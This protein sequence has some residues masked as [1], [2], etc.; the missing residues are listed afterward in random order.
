[1]QSRWRRQSV[2]WR[3]SRNLNFSSLK[4]TGLK[5]EL[6]VVL[7]AMPY[8]V[9]VILTL[10]VLPCWFFGGKTP[11]SWTGCKVLMQSFDILTLNH[12]QT[13]RTCKQSQKP[14]AK[15]NIYILEIC[16]RHWQSG[17]LRTRGRHGHHV[18]VWRGKV[19][20]MALNVFII[21]KTI[22]DVRCQPGGSTW[23][24]AETCKTPAKHT[25]TTSHHSACVCWLTN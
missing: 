20:H 4:G 23:N 10:A 8:A 6:F 24:C 13:A 19:F 11:R 16:M 5:G 17:Y 7:T 21:I 3:T 12:N 15:K 25:W 2:Y 1:M 14:G 9:Y 22:S 18:V